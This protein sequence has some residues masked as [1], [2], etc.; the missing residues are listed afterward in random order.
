MLLG[1]TSVT[2]TGTPSVSSSIRRASVKPFTA[3]LLAQYMPWTGIARSD[4]TEPT[5]MSAARV[6]LSRV[7]K[8]RAASREP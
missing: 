8:C 1:L 6:D 2:D 7:R 4:R 5:L 3:N